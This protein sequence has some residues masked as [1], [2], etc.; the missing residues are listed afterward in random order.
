MQRRSSAQPRRKKRPRSRDAASRPASARINVYQT[1]PGRRRMRLDP[2][3]RLVKRALS[4]ES[5]KIAALNIILA[6]DPY[7]HRLNLRFFGKDR[8]T[9]VISF[10]LGEVSEIYVSLDRARD[11]DEVHYY[12]LHGLL[13][14]AGYDHRDRKES[15]RMHRKCLEHLSYE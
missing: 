12:I 7:L 10:D 14:L 5:M 1:V 13:H 11:A 9:N 4:A 6:D 15:A 3:R 8:R 2:I